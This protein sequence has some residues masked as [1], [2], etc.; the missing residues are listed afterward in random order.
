MKNKAF[1]GFIFLVGLLLFLTGMYWLAI[2]CMIF[3]VAYYILFCIGIWNKVQYYKWL[4]T[5]LAFSG[6]VLITICIRIFFFSIYAISSGSMENTLIPGDKI[7]VNKLSF[8]P[9]IP[10]STAEI[11][12]IGL[13]FS[14]NKHPSDKKP[15]LWDYVRLNGYSK[16]C[17]G[18]VMVFRHPIWGKRN[19]IFIKRCVAIPGDTVA[20]KQSNL[21]VNQKFIPELLQVKKLYRIWTN[22]PERLYQLKDSIGIEIINVS[23]PSNHQLVFEVQLSQLQY[24]T[25]LQQ[26]FADS[27][28]LKI[29]SK[30]SQQWLYP[31][32][33]EF[34]WTLD[35]YGPL[36][37]PFKGFT[38]SLNP[39][40][41]KL[42]QRTI[43]R[44]E[45]H[46]LEEKNGLYYLD[47]RRTTYYTF[48][49]NYY[50]MMG[51]NR[52]NSRDSRD[53]GV[54]PE[55]NIIGKAAYILFSNPLEA[56]KWARILKPIN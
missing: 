15:A 47:S 24:H 54:V 39:K 53:W 31:K 29:S 9:E 10:R 55:E 20:I 16:N 22:N 32:S 42:Y 5:I 3:T 52:N 35:D 37:I 6:I 26:S 48:R 13:V 8:G 34:S 49:H 46:T 56:F 38:I 43:N 27:I 44:L 11:P 19:N 18:H 36:I 14:A 50:F 1:T 12:W 51:D 40:N 2:S 21:F 25:I 23:G 17:R 7:L 41:F 45:Q 4:P 28:K 33:E 30:E